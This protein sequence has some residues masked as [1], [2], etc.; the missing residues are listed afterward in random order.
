MFATIDRHP[1]F[2]LAFALLTTYLLLQHLLLNTSKS[3]LTSRRKLAV[4]FGDSITQMGFDVAIMG[5]V[6]SLAFRYSRR[7][8]VINRGLSGYN[9]RW[10]LTVFDEAVIRLKPDLVILFFGNLN[11]IDCELSTWDS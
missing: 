5:W 7:M 11:H 10:A 9:T 2:F 8:D 6:A 4:T 3:I 1:I